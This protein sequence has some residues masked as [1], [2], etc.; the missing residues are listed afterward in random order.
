M[1][2]RECGE[3]IHPLVRSIRAPDQADPALIPALHD[4]PRVV[5]VPV[6]DFDQK[7]HSQPRAYEGDGAV[8]LVGLINQ[9]RPDVPSEEELPHVLERFA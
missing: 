3:A 9:P 1:V 5:K 8:V 7:R 4:A 6:S 2:A